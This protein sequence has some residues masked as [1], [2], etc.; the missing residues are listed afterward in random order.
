MVAE[1]SG[2]RITSLIE[3]LPEKERLIVEEYYY[4]GLSFIEITQK[5]PNLSKSWIS[6]LH[7]RALFRLRRML[8]NE[9]GEGIR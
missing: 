5:F 6:R 4:K 8:L 1:E 2:R 9:W 7:K 3:S